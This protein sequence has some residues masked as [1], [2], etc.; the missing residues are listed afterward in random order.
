MIQRKSESHGRRGNGRGAFVLVILTLSLPGPARADSVNSPN[1]TL[2][3]D[4]NRTGGAGAGNVAVVVNTI[5]LAEISLPEYSSGAGKKVT[6]RARPG[7]A[8][9]PASDI[10]AQSATIG[11]NGTAVNGVA[12]ITPS[13][14]AEELVTFNLTSGT[15]TS[16]QDIIRINGIRLLILNAAGAAGPAQ[17]TISLTTSAAG[18]SFTNQG[19]VAA[20]IATGAAD[21]LV[22][23]TAPGN[24]QAGADLLPAVSIVD[25]GGNTV[26]N[27]ARN[28][29]LAIAS[30]PGAATLLGTVQKGTVNGVA[31][32]ANADDLRINVAAA[33]Y[34]LR[35]SHDGAAFLTS[36]TTDSSAFAITAGSPGRLTFLQQP[37]TTAAGENLLVSV[38]ALDAFDNVILS[39]TIPVTLG[40]AVNPG[41]GELLSNTGLTKNTTQGVATWN[42]ADALRLT[43]KGE[44]FQLSA[45]GVGAPVSSDAFDIT[46]AAPS[47]TRFVQGPSTTP[48][49]AVM[50]PPVV[51]EI[52]DAFGNRTDA[53]ADIQV[54]LVTAPCGGS[55]SGGVVTAVNGVSTFDL[56]VFDTP[57]EGNELRAATAGLPYAKSE[58]FSITPVAGMQGAAAC[59]ICGQGLMLSAIPA[60]VIPLIWRRRRWG[61]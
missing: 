31:T 60:M 34:T 24:A 41:S 3:V 61:R 23:S 30:N 54:S 28:I 37:A 43:V 8:F 21:R 10:T 56:L 33:G 51:V 39:D 9:D 45:S 40:L 16:V 32:W 22:F 52:I 38:M 27:D 7:F 50:A 46:A 58:P 42:A 47:T 12:V 18:G 4:T 19:I 5:T 59:G 55:V 2:N 17:T 13:G 11:I 6:L 35:A 26:R 20:N 57:C 1:I 29:T 14:I 48:E 36:N 53:G 15:N 44:G 49:D 25:F